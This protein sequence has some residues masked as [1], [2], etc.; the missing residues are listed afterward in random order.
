MAGGSFIIRLAS[1]VPRLRSVLTASF[2][3][4]LSGQALG[5]TFSVLH[6][7]SDVSG[8]NAANNDGA[9]PASSLILSG[10]ALYGTAQFGGGS[11]Q[12]AVFSVNTDG[13]GFIAPYSFT[14]GNDGANPIA[15]LILSNNTLYGTASKGGA[16]G[17][18][19]VFA[20]S[21]DGTVFS[22]FHSFSAPVNNSHGARTNSDGAYPYVGLLL[23]GNNLY[24]A[25]NNGGTS[26]Q[27]TLFT[28]STA[29]TGFTNLHSFGSG[30][31]GA[32]SSA[33]LIFVGNKLY[34]AN[35]A[36]LGNGTVFAIGANGTG[37]TNYYAFS[38]GLL[39]ERGVMTNSDGANPLAKLVV[40]GNTL[41]GTTQNGG[42]FGNGTVFAVSTDG[43]AF[44]TLHH[45]AAGAYAP[46]GLFTNSDGANPSAELMLT[47][48]HL[49]GTAYAGG[50]A[51]NGT[52]FAVSTD[53][54]TFTNLHNFSATPPYP[55]P[56]TNC[57]GANPSGGLVLSG[58]TFYGTTSSGG[59][60]G[61][62]T[63]FSLSLAPRIAIVP[64]SQ[65][66]V[67]SWPS[68]A[69]GFDY[70]GF[71]LQTSLATT[72]PFTNIAGATNP[73]TNPIANAQQ[74]FRLSQ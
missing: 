74:Y 7:F 8:P 73:Y 46:G 52:V 21:T 5:Q 16:F 54:S 47:N 4:V 18:G 35:Y 2:C 68:N 69:A 19:T 17:A 3:L 37:F 53:G 14:G 43:T 58:S 39:N 34:G 70:T 48:N 24:G 36:N 1:W 12:G 60:A 25:A 40:S 56:Q 57:D 41:F 11:G 33:G 20:V 22:N 9:N 49:Y 55:A 15:S 26:G 13:S 61:N 50:K 32:Y 30:T 51:G 67:L 63:L 71:K 28:V 38:Q 62:G 72:G 10:S 44:T 65:N 27:G 64:S 31:G 6:T 23:S 42:L 45:F 66:V 29:A 59:A